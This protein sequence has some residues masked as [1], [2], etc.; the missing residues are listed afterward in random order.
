[1]DTATNRVA[2]AEHAKKLADKNATFYHNVADSATLE[3]K[4]IKV[5]LEAAKE[6]MQSSHA[7]EKDLWAEVRRLRDTVEAMRAT[8]STD[9][10][11]PDTVWSAE[12]NRLR[13]ALK[14]SEQDAREARARIEA[15]E[16]ISAS[17]YDGEAALAAAVE[18][19]KRLERAEKDV[20]ARAEVAEAES[21][22][23]R[24]AE[25][26][27][28][29]RAA[30]LLEQIKTR[31]ARDAN[32]LREAED[33]LQAA[34]EALAASA[35]AEERAN[36]D[37]A[38]AR[39][40]A[41]ER[42]AKEREE[43]RNERERLVSALKDAESRLAS[44]NDPVS[45]AVGPTE[46]SVLS[47]ARITVAEADPHAARTTA[48]TVRM[49]AAADRKRADDAVSEVETLRTAMCEAQIAL[50]V[51]RI[52]AA[53][54]LA[55]AA[56]RESELT[57]AL[58]RSEKSA[59]SAVHATARVAQ[60]E[61]DL[62]KTSAN[63][64]ASKSKIDK[65][66]DELGETRLAVQRSECAAAELQ[67]LRSAYASVMEA[68]K[69]SEEQAEKHTADVRTL[70]RNS[71]SVKKIS[72][73]AIHD[74][75]D[76]REELEKVHERS[77]SPSSFQSSRRRKTPARKGNGWEECGIRDITKK[78]Y[79]LKL[80]SEVDSACSDM[81][82]YDGIEASRASVGAKSPRQLLRKKHYL[83]T[84]VA[85]ISIFTL[86]LFAS[87]ARTLRMELENGVCVEGVLGFAIAAIEEWLSGTVR[88]PFRLPCEANL[89]PPS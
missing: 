62:E 38:E 85:L 40:S 4:R 39:A 20:T 46:S 56:K 18:E 15:A 24:A 60:L 2:D 7:R 76:T 21:S 9:S 77:P 52:D 42:L 82:I 43:A 27:A 41:S 47:C 59:A 63:A 54:Q 65:L 10:L 66:V 88:A 34:R 28:E 33:A 13:G 23:A 68:L 8:S 53:F 19:I 67:D 61:A 74:A 78:S 44:A 1:L 11:C 26:S 3:V 36:R 55:E 50:E 84:A 83:Q 22:R 29:A 49:S 69:R 86:L 87:R 30:E 16:S 64:R 45:L 25:K 6:E 89:S 31:P 51:S 73:R 12:V 79:R 75:A 57:A 35:S 71:Q 58:E 81:G 32:E 70:P 48:D 17:K 37:A 80:D 5:K 14:S 72:S